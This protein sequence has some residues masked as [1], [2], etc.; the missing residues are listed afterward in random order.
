MTELANPPVVVGRSLWADAWR[1]LLRNRMALIGLVVVVV[2]SLVA[3]A[4]PWIVPRDPQYQERWIGAQAPGF[5]HP[6]VANQVQVRVGEVARALALTP[7]IDEVEPGADYVIELRVVPRT[8]EEV[9]LV[10]RRPKAPAEVGAIRRIEVTDPRTG[11]RRELDRLEVAGGLERLRL[12]DDAGLLTPGIVL[13]K[14]KLPPE[15]MVAHARELSRPIGGR[16][17]WVYVL[18]W[19]HRVREVDDLV[20][21]GISGQRVVKVSVNGEG[22]EEFSVAGSDVSAASFNGAPLRHTHW[23]GTDLVG[24][25]VL[26]RVIFGGRISLLIGLVAT[27]VSVTIG[28]VYGAVSGYFSDRVVSLGF[29]LLGVAVISALAGV[30]SLYWAGE[31]RFSG[32]WQF[33]LFM[34]TAGGVCLVVTGLSGALGSGVQKLLWWPLTTVDGLMMR[35]VDILYTLP[36]M[37]L[38]ILLMVNFGNN[39]VMLFVALG[40]VQW[41]TMARI[42]RGQALSLKHKEF[43]EAAQV[44]GASDLAII[45]EHIIPNVLGVVAVYATLTIPSVILQESFLSFIGLTVQW[46]GQSLESWGALIN[47]GTDALEKDGGR[48]WLLLVPSLAMAITLFSMNFVGDGLRDALDPRMRG[49]S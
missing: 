46:D 47:Y 13:I 27:L 18:S 8:T 23:L 35:L 43:I 17:G 37:F 33:L 34:L 28:V 26:S 2:M 16:R 49:R 30:A 40:A 38:V 21:V 41:L 42:V 3:T 44:A 4:A 1:R 36:Y 7:R 31:A 39:I 32:S 29:V 20:E 14:G 10:M 25:D 6:E 5:T 22:R 12:E 15:E 24:R 19:E 9:R 11:E 45:V 48:S